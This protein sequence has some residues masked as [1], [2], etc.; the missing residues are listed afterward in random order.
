MDVLALAGRW[1]A[2]SLALVASAAPAIAAECTQSSAPI[3]TDRPDITNSSVVVPVGSFQSEN[4]VNISTREGAQIFDGTNSR[5]RLGIAPCLEVL[6]DVSTYVTPVSGSGASG[7]TDVAPA[8]KWQISPIPG[9][10]DLSVVAGVALPTG[11]IT[12]AGR[13][14]QPYLQF[15]W[16][17]ELN[18]G[19]AF[20]GM[21]TNFFTPDDRL[22]HYT[23]Q[24]TSVIERQFGERAFVF[25]EYIGDFPLIGSVTHR[26]NFG[27]GVRITP[28]QQIDF[29]AGIGLNHNAPAYVFGIG[30]SFRL[31]GLFTAQSPG[32]AIIPNRMTVT[33]D[34]G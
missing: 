24:S 13:G 32:R 28:T 3:E 7:F 18:S 16:S 23:N 14:A 34:R 33:P 27:G 15:P 30:Y 11:T 26:L 25:A 6:L 9:K 8:V 1:F 20:T 31:D 10:F 22:N 4:G 5:L 21:V 12:I 29:H 17:Y 2:A 19:W